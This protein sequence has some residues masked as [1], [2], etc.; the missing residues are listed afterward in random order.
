MSIEAKRDARKRALENLETAR[1]AVE[2][3]QA[4]L[5]RL[6]TEVDVA[7]RAEKVAVSQIVLSA[8]SR[9]REAN[10]S[11]LRAEAVLASEL[12]E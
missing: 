3:A 10:A 5:E 1:A 6:L 7:P 12:E 9:L 11:V 4:D 2:S 8:L